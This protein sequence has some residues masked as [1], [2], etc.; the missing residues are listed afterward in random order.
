MRQAD[1]TKQLLFEAFAGLPLSQRG[2]GDISLE[3]FIDALLPVISQSPTPFRDRIID[4]QVGALAV[5]LGVGNT[6]VLFSLDPVPAGEI[7]R[8]VS[9]TAVA[10]GAAQHVLVTIVSNG[11]ELS[12]LHR[13]L[14]ANSQTNLLTVSDLDAAGAL[15]P[16]R[17]IPSG[18]GHVDVYPGGILRLLFADMANTETATFL[19]IRLRMHGP[20]ETANDLSPS[21]NAALS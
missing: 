15:A 17:G 7:H 18:P 6:A 14:T 20:R 9:L 19:A 16:E 1:S 5:V 2:A 12:V 4:F 11:N 8:Y 21:I 3:T 13:E 10:T